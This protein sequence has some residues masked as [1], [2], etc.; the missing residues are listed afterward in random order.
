MRYLVPEVKC[1][2]SSFGLSSREYFPVRFNS[3]DLLVKS[4]RFDGMTLAS[5]LGITLAE[6]FNNCGLIDF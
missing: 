1:G 2:D 4:F 3:I 6:A 5:T